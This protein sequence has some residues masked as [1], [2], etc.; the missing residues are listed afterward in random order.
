MLERFKS[1]IQ[2]NELFSKENRILLAVSGGIDSV[3]MAHLFKLAGYE[4]AIAH[5]NFMLRGAESDIDEDF[6]RQLGKKLDIPFLSVSFNTLKVAEER[7]ISIQMAARDLRYEWFNEVSIMLGYDFIATAHHLN[8]SIE[9][10]LLNFTKGCGIRGLHGIPVKNKNKVRPLLFATREA[11]EKFAE[12]YQ[13]SYRED[14]SNAQKKYA[15]NQ[16]RLEVIPALKN[17]N[18]SFEA[19]AAKT[20]KRIQ[21]AESLFHFSLEH[22]KSALWKQKGE[23][24]QID[25]PGLKNA[26]GSWTLLYEM[27]KDFGFHPDQTDQVLDA[28][29]NTGALFFS[30]THRM[31]LDRENLW[32]EPLS[33]DEKIVKHFVHKGDT[34]IELETGVLLLDLKQGKPDRFSSDAN[35]AYL[36]YSTLKFPLRIRPWT[37]GDVFQPIGMDGRNKKLKDLFV[38][39]KLSVFEKEKALILE[40]GNGEIIWVISHRADERFKIREQTTQHIV[41]AFFQKA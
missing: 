33:E 29:T 6:C 38:D 4:T 35:F 2:E 3:V 14:T 34:R 30:K 15:R 32:I 13:V 40:N 8:D 9:T 26:P 23:Q 39:A 37:P 17:I 18:P 28:Q 36:D 10:F 31:L 19:S 21:D 16:I 24:V 22:F 1:F 5:C 27:V 41:A 12:A 20:I 11:I 25:L 7:G